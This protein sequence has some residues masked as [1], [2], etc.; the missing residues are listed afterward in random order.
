[1]N[2]F[3]TLLYGTTTPPLFV[4]KI[5]YK[6]R[7]LFSDAPQQTYIATELYVNTRAL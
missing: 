5:N 6:F 3:S 4:Q 7:Y 2:L 1:M